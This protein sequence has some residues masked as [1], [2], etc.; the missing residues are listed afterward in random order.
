MVTINNYADFITAINEHEVC[1]VKIGADWCGP[2]KVVQKNIEDIEK[3]HSDVYF[4]DVDAE[5]ADDIVDEFGVR[6]VPVV[7]VVK[8][9]EVDSKTVGVQTQAQLEDRLN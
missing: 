3:L 7:L 1:L 5:E 2:C 6:N 4:I 9:G 8:N